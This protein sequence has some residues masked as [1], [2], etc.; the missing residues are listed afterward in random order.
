MDLR[1]LKN[2]EINRE[3]WDKGIASSHH[4]LIYAESWYLDIC[5][6]DWSAI[7]DVDYGF[8]FPLPV[9]RSIGLSLVMQPLFVQQLGIFSKEVPYPMTLIDTLQKIRYPVVNLN[10]NSSMMVG[11]AKQRSENLPGIPEY[12]STKGVISQLGRSVRL[13]EN[14]ILPLTSTYEQLAVNFSDNCRRNLKISKQK[15]FGTGPCNSSD[16]FIDFTKKHLNYSISDKNLRLLKGIVDEALQRSCGFIIS[17][18]NS[19]GEPLAMAFFLNKYGRL[20]FLSGS[21]SL[22]GLEYRSM[23]AIIDNVIREYAGTG[24][25]LDFEGSDL[26]GVRRFYEGFGSQKEY[27]P[28]FENHLLLRLWNLFRRVKKQHKK[29]GVRLSFNISNYL[30]NKNR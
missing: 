5:S 8:L 17:C 12:N 9:N 15:S 2:K 21:S 20:T 27:Y 26:S 3:L 19:K 25:I 7:V 13:K 22:Q 1:F 30:C 4:P 29:S 16:Q 6:P 23:F 10:G 11:S 18:D 14:C 28:A 24:I